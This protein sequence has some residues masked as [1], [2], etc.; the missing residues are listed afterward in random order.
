VSQC[1]AVCSTSGTDL[2]A[3]DSN[4]LVGEQCGNRLRSKFTKVSSLQKISRIVFLCSKLS[5]A[6]VSSSET[7]ICNSQLA[8]QFTP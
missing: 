4:V 2:E 8:D 1:V 6:K 5:T 7:T 3:L